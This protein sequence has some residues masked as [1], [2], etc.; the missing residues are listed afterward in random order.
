MSKSFNKFKRKVR[1]QSA[2]AALLLGLGAGLIALAAIMITFKLLGKDVDLYYYIICGGGGVIA[3]VAL[4]FVF[5]PSDKRL[6]KRLDS[7]YSL[8]EK[9]STMI[10]LKDENHG[11]AEL[12]REDAEL[13]LSEKPAKAF[14]SKQLLAG[15]LVF[16]IAIGSFVGSWLVPAKAEEQEAPIDAF[17]KEWLITALQELVDMAE[18]S[19]VQVNL[20]EVTVSELKS[21][22]SFVEGSDLLSE[23]KAEAVKTVITVNKTL[24]SVNSAEKIGERFAESSNKSISALGEEMV[25][26]SGS[27]VR[28]TMEELGV[29]IAD[30]SADD[31]EFIGDEMNAL[32]QS[33][34][35]GNEDALLQLFKTLTALAKTDNTAAEDEFVSAGKQISTA[36]VSQGVNKT[37]TNIIINKLCSLFGITESD[38]T[39]VDPETEVEIRDPAAKDDGS[40]DSEVEEPDVNISSGGL[41]TGEVIYGSDDIIYDPFTNT[42]RP[43]GEIINDYFA[44]ANE[45]I[46]DGKASDDISD[47][48]EEYFAALFGGSK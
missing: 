20:K 33:C 35:V 19:R 7:L 44:K 37:T 18:N 11:F 40:D 15:I 24:Q 10:A 13:H 29:A 21:L 28:R 46:T 31:A 23:M 45:Q 12:Q 2:L 36:L 34:G 8:D 27:G 4:Y 47:V 6:A 38:I 30:A 16:F 32:L 17:D 41:G 22:L 26:Y 5:T 1:I 9:V 42:Y 48:A 25:N 43:Y 14:R 3:S 39:E